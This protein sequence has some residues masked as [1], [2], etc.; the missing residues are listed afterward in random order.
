MFSHR[1]VMGIRDMLSVCDLYSTLH[2]LFLFVHNRQQ[3]TLIP[4]NLLDNSIS[5]IQV[6]HNLLHIQ[7][8]QTVKQSILAVQSG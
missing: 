3:G 7:D 8:N 1:E 2:A 6:T 4:V 5:A